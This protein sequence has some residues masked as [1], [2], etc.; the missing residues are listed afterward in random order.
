MSYGTAG[1]SF[2]VPYE[3]SGSP[4]PMIFHA[5][6]EI[7]AMGIPRYTCIQLVTTAFFWENYILGKET[8]IKNKTQ[9]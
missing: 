7:L 2:P 5:L 9:N 1:W 3:N 6:N 4:A 8:A